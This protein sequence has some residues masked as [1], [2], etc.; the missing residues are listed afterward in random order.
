MTF[1]SVE[2]VDTHSL[3]ALDKMAWQLEEALPA[4]CIADPRQ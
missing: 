3:N 2:L 4:L 1:S